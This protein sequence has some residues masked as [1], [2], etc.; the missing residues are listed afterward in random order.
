[1]GRLSIL[2]LLFAGLFLL[3][4]IFFNQFEND[5]IQLLM[6]LC[7]N[8]SLACIGLSILMFSGIVAYE[9]TSRQTAP[10]I[11]WGTK[12]FINHTVGHFT[13]RSERIF[14]PSCEGEQSNEE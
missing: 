11:W 12:E 9:R 14:Q 7:A 6:T 3:A 4:F 2:S 13:D 8:L 5:W 10:S 1:M